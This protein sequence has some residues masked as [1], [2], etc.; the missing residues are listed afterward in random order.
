MAGL[1]LDYGGMKGVDGGSKEFRI[2]GPTCLR[3]RSASRILNRK[4]VTF[5][6]VAA[7]RIQ[8]TG[9]NICFLSEEFVLCFIMNEGRF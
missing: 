1:P 5:R 7:H 8:F 9:A 4:I 3:E 2:H 6:S